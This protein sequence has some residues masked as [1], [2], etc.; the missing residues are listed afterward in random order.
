M[1]PVPIGVLASSVTWLPTDLPN[2]IGWWDASNAASF[3]YSS[4]TNVSAWASR[5]GS[6]S[7]SQATALKQPTRSGTVNG[8]PSVV[9]NGTSHS[10]VVA[11]FDLTGSNKVSAWIVFSATS[12]SNPIVIE[13]TANFNGTNGAWVLN[14]NTSNQIGFGRRTSTSPNYSDF[15]TTA[16]LTTPPKIAVGIFDGALS[17]NE[18]SAWVNTDGSGTRPNNANTTENNVSA[19]MYIGSRGGSTRYLDGQICEMGV[20][21]AALSDADRLS[22]TTYLAAKWGVTL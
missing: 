20:N 7:A 15:A 2:L 13:H 3:T 1:S 10:L 11:S 16:T 22:L 12:G 14:R 17:T 18:A 8:L 4:G 19:D 9:F 5:V 6:Y 21:R